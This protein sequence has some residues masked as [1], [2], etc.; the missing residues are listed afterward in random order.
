MR[1]TRDDQR[2]PCFVNQRR[3]D[4]VNNR[5]LTLPLYLLIHIPL[6]VVAEVV[7]PELRSGA[8]DDIAAV[9]LPLGGFG[10]H[11]HRVDRADRQT[12][13]RKEREGPVAVTLD[14]VIIHRDHMHLLAGHRRHVSRERRDDGLA[15]ARLHFRDLALTQ[16]HATDQLH[17]KRTSTERRTRFRINLP[18]RVVNL[19]WNIDLDIRRDRFSTPKVLPHR[20]RRLK[21]IH[22]RLHAVIRLACR[23]TQKRRIKPMFRIKDVADPHRTIH[24]FAPHR[25]YLDQQI[26][27]GLSRVV[28]LPELFGLGAKLS[29]GQRSHLGLKLRDRVYACRV[30]LDHTLIA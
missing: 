7:K 29:I 16:H 23:A 22:L 28:P 10:L 19:V 24:R 5:E 21:R 27:R 20:L 1:R 11:V 17:I 4:F 9:H 2:R 13:L 18:N 14:E 30:P 3:V 26:V 25:E 12:D 6:H 8:V 15:F